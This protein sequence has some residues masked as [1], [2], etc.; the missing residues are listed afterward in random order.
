MSGRAARA[1]LT[2]TPLRFA[3]RGCLPLLAA[4]IVGCSPTFNWRDVRLD[5]RA[6]P[7][8]A[9][10]PCKPDQAERPVSFDGGPAV[11]LSMIGC[12]TGGDTFTLAHLAV[13]DP[14]EAAAALAQWRAANRARLGGAESQP[15]AFRLAGTLELPA[16]GGAT[17]ETRDPAGQ[18]LRQ[19]AAW[20]ARAGSGG[21]VELFQVA[22]LGAT[23]ER[24]VADT[25]FSSLRF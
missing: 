25:F 10:L 15:V 23:I 1:T 21:A 14:L 22:M 19:R 13:A 18:P 6:G 3:V 2:R 12:S 16:S 9:L 7:L 5:S 24:G 8:A 20:F 17:I 4:T 11:P